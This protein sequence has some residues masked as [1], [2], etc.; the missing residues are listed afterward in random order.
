MRKWTNKLMTF[1][2]YASV[3]IKI[4]A[5]WQSKLLLASMLVRLKWFHLV[6]HVDEGLY[7]ADI[8]LGTMKRRVFLRTQDIFI[9]REIFGENPYI[10]PEMR[11]NPPRCILD[12]GAH[13]GL[14]TLQFKAAFPDAEIH[15]YEPDPENFNILQLN[16]E[17]LLGIILYQ[18]AVGSQRGKATFYVR[19]DR[20]AGSSLYEGGA[21]NS[22]RTELIECETE[23]LD[24]CL[25]Q[26]SMPVDI[27]KFDIEG[28]EFETFS[29][30]RQIH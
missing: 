25:N 17:G 16:T 7:V 10:L 8:E 30:S 24:D 6:G 13:I 9:V 19:H 29:R 1:L 4:G 21:E 23:P 20:H 5:N 28:A 26:T 27:V 15:C 12:L 14:A 22:S 3:G 11:V 2:E 18:K